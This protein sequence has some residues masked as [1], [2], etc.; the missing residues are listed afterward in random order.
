MSSA[1][2]VQP[3]STSFTCP[4]VTAR[5]QCAS[6]FLWEASQG[7]QRVGDDFCLAPHLSVA[8]L[9][10]AHSYHPSHCPPISLSLSPS[11]VTCSKNATLSFSSAVLHF[12]FQTKAHFSVCHPDHDWQRA[13]AFVVLIPSQTFWKMHLTPEQCSF[14]NVA[15]MQVNVGTLLPLPGPL[16]WTLL[17]AL[18]M[19]ST[20]PFKPTEVV[21]KRG[22]PC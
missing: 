4:C 12:V 21:A 8:Y 2:E 15:V 6:L 1:T 14:V 16:T 5:P 9:N 7:F 17:A 13:A 10:H 18:I 19:K 11:A 22:S 3:S 20:I